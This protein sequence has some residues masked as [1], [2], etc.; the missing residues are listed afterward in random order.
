VQSKRKRLELQTFVLNGLI[1]F[2]NLGAARACTAA[3]AALCAWHVIAWR[4]KNNNK[5][6]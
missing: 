3:A 4:E 6:N 5:K 2:F 1:K